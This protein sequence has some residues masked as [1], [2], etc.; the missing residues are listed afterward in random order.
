MPKV[1]SYSRFST[2]EQAAGDSERR[3]VE[4]AQS[5]AAEHGLELDDRLKIADLGVSAYRG[6]NLAPDAGLGKFLDAVKQGLVDAG[7]VLLLESLDRFSRMEP[8]KV[9]HELTGLLLAGVQVATLADGKIYSRESLAKDNGL[10]LM[11][12]LMVAIRAHEESETKGRRVAAAWAQKRKEMREGKADKLTARA[13]AWLRWTG[14]EWATDQTKADTVRRVYALTLAGEGEHKIAERFNREGLPPLGRGKRWHRSSVAKLLRNRAVIG[15]LVPGHIEHK[16]GKKLRVL[17]DPIPGAFPAIISEDDWQAVRA[18][19]DG[20]A[21]AVRGIA[22]ARPLGNVLAGLARCPVCGSTMTRVSKGPK[23]GAAK[24]VCTRAK[25]GAG[26]QYKS[27]PLAEV[28]DAILHK[29]DRLIADVPAGERG[30]A[31]DREAFDLESTIAGTIDHLR[32]LEDALAANPSQA[33]ARRLAQLEAEL[34]THEAAMRDLE[35]ERRLVD[36]GLIRAR[37][38]RLHMAIEAAREEGESFTDRE[39]INATLKVLFDGVTVDY[40]N[41]RL[42]FHWRQGGVSEMLYAWPGETEWIPKI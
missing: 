24:L 19:K 34:R 22:A 6:A 18:L 40:P 42:L 35:E 8:V 25:A 14:E 7:S 31:I 26:C 37:A 20:R 12:A 3:Q 16:D 36:G 4:A 13:P 23:G 11:I 10:G 30:G 29:A 27:V 39:P 15:D 38:E 2:P 9:Q 21:G 17:E 41:K 33:G 1:Y 5:F 28:E 32:D